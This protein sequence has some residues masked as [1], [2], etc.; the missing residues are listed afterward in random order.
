M[1]HEPSGL[2]GAGPMRAIVRS[3]RSE[4]GLLVSP[5]DAL[6]VAPGFRGIVAATE[7]DH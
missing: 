3:Y 7:V 1:V 2:D 5:A 6:E 4:A